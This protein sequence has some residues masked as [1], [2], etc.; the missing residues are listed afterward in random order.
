MSATDLEEPIPEAEQLQCQRDRCD[1]HHD[2]DPLF[3]AAYRKFCADPTADAESD[4]QQ[5]R[6]APSNIAL[7]NE[8]RQRNNGGEEDEDDLDI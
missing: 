5:E 3:A 7:D 2:S 4:R 8:H 1:D 6:R